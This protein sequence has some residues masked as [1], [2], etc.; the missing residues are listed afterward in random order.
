MQK[1]SLNCLFTYYIYSSL[2]QHKTGDEKKEREVEEN[3][4]FVFSNLLLKYRHFLKGRRESD[5]C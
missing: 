3:L 4:S 1:T 2:T 5:E